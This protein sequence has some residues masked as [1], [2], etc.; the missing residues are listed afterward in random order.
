[1]PG[2]LD[3]VHVLDVSRVLTGPYASMML[4]DLGAEVIKIEM[5]G[6][7]D[8]T[9]AWGP[10]FQGGESAY[11]LSVNRNKKSVTLNLK[12]P[13]GREILMK[14]AARSDV[15]LE[16]FA[17]GVATRLGIDYDAVR[18]VRPDIVYCSISG[19]GQDG[20]YR[21]LP[22]YDII[23]Q[24]MGGIQ[25]ITGEP[26]RP[27]VRVGVAI[28]DIAGGMFAAFAIAAALVRRERTGRGEYIDVALLDSQLAWLTYMAGY[29]FAE[30]TEPVRAGS[31]HPQIVPYQAFETSDG[32][33]NVAVGNDALFR[34]FAEALG[35][36]DLAEDARFATNP[37][38]VKH[39]GDLEPI[40][41]QIFRAKPTS[42]WMPILNEAGVPAGPVYR[43]GQIAADPHVRARGNVLS[44][45]HPTVGPM[46]QFGPP[47]RPRT[48]R[49]GHSPPPRLGENTDEIL[50]SLGYSSEG[51]RQLRKLGTV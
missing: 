35:R 34:R 11:F 5:P 31:K 40:L 38:R 4:A 3:G 25:A 23:L 27:P 44:L 21:D 2:L 48:D 17:P 7:G 39:R 22:A 12:A 18:A 42:E 51:I 1:M 45:D 19:F 37:E 10:P 13:E 14:L 26:D 20:P 24:G 33:V 43:I 36:A 30:G 15:F 50:L 28:A 41:E 6:R 16:N 32:Y 46:R 49:G 29:Y 47:Y 8:D 9:R